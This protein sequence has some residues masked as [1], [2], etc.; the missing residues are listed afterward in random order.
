M[1]EASEELKASTQGEVPTADQVAAA[2][3]EEVS[4]TLGQQKRQFEGAIRSDPLRSVAV[5]AVGGFLLAV[6][7]RRL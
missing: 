1:S 6:L 4:E 7:V 5:A 2:T 3:A